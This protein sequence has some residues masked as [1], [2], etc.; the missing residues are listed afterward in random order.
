MLN[1]QIN[2]SASDDADGHCTGHQT[3]PLCTILSIWRMWHYV[4]LRNLTSGIGR[5]VAAKS[6]RLRGR[7]IRHNGFI[8]ERVGASFVPISLYGVWVKPPGCRRWSHSI[9]II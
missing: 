2:W 8:R 7:S 3:A 5:S 1:V 4:C 6:R 9:V